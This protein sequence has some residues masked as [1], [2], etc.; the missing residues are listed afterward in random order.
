MMYNLWL[1]FIVIRQSEIGNIIDR[2]VTNKFSVDYKIT[3]G[4][5]SK[6]KDF[7]YEEGKIAK[8]SF[9]DIDIDTNRFEKIMKSFYKGSHGALLLFDLKNRETFEKVKKKYTEMKRGC[10]FFIGG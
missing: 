7:E 3:C 4:V 2:I 5:D 1:K 10:G 6:S 8:V 9:W